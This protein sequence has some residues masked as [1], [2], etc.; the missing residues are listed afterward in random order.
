MIGFVRDTIV[1]VVGIRTAVGVL[2]AVGVFGLVWAAVERV[3]DAVLIVVGLGAAV[4]VLIAI[5][6]FG[7]VRTG[8]VA[9]CD[10]VA[11]GVRT[12]DRGDLDQGTAGGRTALPG[13]QALSGTR[14]ELRLLQMI[15]GIARCALREVCPRELEVRARQRQLARRAIVTT[16]AQHTLEPPLDL[17]DVAIDRARVTAPQ[18]RRQRQSN[19]HRRT[20]SAEPGNT[21]AARGARGMRPS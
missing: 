3:D 21:A 6:I 9:V 8:V 14:V 15:F 16:G 13:T 7:L 2:I 5:R 17:G 20:R 12:V 1:I 11:V 10:A 18:T 4:S 19:K